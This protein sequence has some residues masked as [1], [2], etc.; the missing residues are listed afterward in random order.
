MARL[1]RPLTSTNR[2][3]L[4][5]EIKNELRH[6]A[7]VNKMIGRGGCLLVMLLMLAVPV[8]YCASVVAKTGL[9]RVPVLTPWLYAPA[10]PSRKVLP[11]GGSTSASV[12]R[13][14]ATRSSYDPHFGTVTF[15]V[16][17]AELT[18][19]LQHAVWEAPDGQLPFKIREAQV[20]VDPNEVEVFLVVPRGTSETTVLARM[21]PVVK[22]G[23]LIEF[24]VRQLRIGAQEIPKSAANFLASALSTLVVNAVLHQVASVG[25][26]S[27]IQEG[28][29]GD[30]K[31]LI[32]P[33]KGMR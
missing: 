16:K 32:T 8:L 26:L 31:F 10:T 4:K 23:S 21:K 19:L 6:E 5:K 9:A 3:E 20:A 17:E 14:I 22:E 2:E 27:S 11:L 15:T 33:F 24:D 12:M 30:L 1:D 7:F 28:D 29:N 25:T 18:T 13:V